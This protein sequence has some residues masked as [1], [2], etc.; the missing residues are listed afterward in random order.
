[1]VL[2]PSIYLLSV[3]TSVVTHSTVEVGNGTAVVKGNGCSEVTNTEG[4]G[5][6]VELERPST[7]PVTSLFHNLSIIQ[8]MCACMHACVH[9]CMHA[10]I[11]VCMLCYS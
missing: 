10:C 7:T 4:V 11:C 9:A 2:S 5:P 8:Q 1:M 6:D 3:P